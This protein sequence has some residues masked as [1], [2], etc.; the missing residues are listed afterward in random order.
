MR[1]LLPSLFLANPLM[2]H[3]A[4]LIWGPKNA[5][6]RPEMRRL[7][8][9]LASLG[10]G[11]RREVRAWIEAGRVTVGG[12][13]GTDPGARVEP[14]DVRIDGEPPDHPG[15]ILLMLNKPPGRVCSHDPAEGPSVFGLLPARWQRRNP[16]VTSVGRLDKE[17]TGLLLLTDCSPIVHRMT[18]PR[19]KVPKVYRATLETALPPGI[20]EAFSSGALLLA[21]EDTPCSPASLRRVGEREAEITVTEGRYHQV[22]R[23][24]ASQGCVVSGLHRTRFG[25]LELGDLPPGKWIELPV[26]S[27]KDL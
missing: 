2:G 18:S 26:S 5:P 7:D 20:E 10:Y 1:V 6:I 8:Q 13:P 22:R 15:E 9:L 19:R 12:A 14:G 25:G 4:M 24:F 21:G 3:S 23:M 27:L 16:P 11:S 17:T